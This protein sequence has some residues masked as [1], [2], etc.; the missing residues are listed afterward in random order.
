MPHS[1]RPARCQNLLD[2]LVESSRVGQCERRLM[3]TV[4]GYV[5]DTLSTE[6]V[7]SD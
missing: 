6:D 1:H 2:G 3:C 5:G 4:G 7:T